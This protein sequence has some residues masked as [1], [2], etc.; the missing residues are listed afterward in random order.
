MKVQD[1][2]VGQCFW[3]GGNTDRLFCRI[4]WNTIWDMF[5]FEE[6]SMALDS[7][8]ILAGQIGCV[9]RG[10]TRTFVYSPNEVVS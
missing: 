7:E 2:L 10:V 3:W 8:V 9:A 1:V 4:G 5:D 6:V